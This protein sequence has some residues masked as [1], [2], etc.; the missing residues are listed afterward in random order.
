MSK[1]N[2]LINFNMILNPTGLNLNTSQLYIDFLKSIRGHIKINNND[3]KFIYNQNQTVILN[4]IQYDLLV[5]MIQNFLYK[6]TDK[7]PKI[8]L[9]FRLI[10]PPNIIPLFFGGFRQKS[11]TFTFNYSHELFLSYDSQKISIENINDNNSS[12]KYII[13]GIICLKG[14]HYYLWYR[15]YVDRCSWSKYDDKHGLLSNRS[16]SIPMAFSASSIDNLKT[17]IAAK[18]LEKFYDFIEDITN[19]TFGIILMHYSI[20][21]K[22]CNSVMKPENQTLLDNVK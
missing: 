9:K 12:Q 2:E 3:K 11:T 6:N 7:N 15:N 1:L 5:N 14:D 20:F 19:H 18:H 10:D 17:L 22:Y 4:D 13:S 16:F 8:N 21:Q